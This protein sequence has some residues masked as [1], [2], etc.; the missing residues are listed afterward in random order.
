MKIEYQVAEKSSSIDPATAENV[1]L[2]AS[3][4]PRKSK[5]SLFG[6]LNRCSS[7]TGIRLL[8]SNLYQPPID[9]DIINDRLELVEELTQDISLFNNL[10][11]IIAKFP[12]L[13][14]VLNLCVKRPEMNITQMEVKLDR[15]I[16][17]KQIL[18][19]LP[20]L[21]EILSKSNSNICKEATKMLRS[22]V[23][24][25]TVLLEMMH[26]VLLEN[27]SFGK[28][29]GA[30]K[31][32]RFMA[33][34]PEVNS[35]LDLARTTFC[36]Y[37][38]LLES[39]V[40]QLAETHE[41][42]MKLQWNNNKGF[43]IQI[44]NSK[45]VQIDVKKL[46]IEFQR[47]VKTKTGITFITQ[48]FAVKDSIAKN[49]LEEVSKL[50]NA[51]LNELLNEVREYIGFLYKLS[52]T[53]AT[54]DMLVAFANVSMQEDYI[55]P[56]FGDS[57]VIRGGRHPNL[58]QIDVDLT[59]NDTNVD[60]FSRLHILTGPNM[61]GKSTYLRQV[62]LLTIMAQIGCFVPAQFATFRITDRIFSRVSTKDCIETNSSTFM[63]EMQETAFI[64]SNLGPSSLVIIDELGRGTSVEEGTAICWAV[65]ESLLKSSSFVFLAT[66]FMQMTCLAEVHPCVE[67][68][69]FLTQ[70]ESNHVVYT[71]Q[72]VKG[73]L[74][75]QGS[76]N[77]NID[78]DDDTGGDINSESE[79]GVVVNYGI[80]LA[81][82]SAF[83]AN[84]VEKAKQISKRISKTEVNIVKVNQLDNLCIQYVVKLKKLANLEES[85]EE[86]R[87]ELERIKNN[88]IEESKNLPEVIEAEE[89]ASNNCEEHIEENPTASVDPPVLPE[90]KSIFHDSELDA[91]NDKT[92][93][94]CKS[95][96]RDPELD[97]EME[98]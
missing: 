37:V 83:P 85:D 36:E 53:V 69:H 19:V 11:N 62:V 59:P 3:L 33:V 26:L 80:D 64:L 89:R 9:K 51:I 42:P 21:L 97:K 73:R 8:R 68:Y 47:I 93:D 32:T 72:L 18:E 46:P 61:S 65:C 14:S 31:F 63:V 81:S 22:H 96:C 58:E 82:R 29:A 60:C 40:R 66:H 49:S 57:L 24:T 12:E 43:C 90:I 56:E 6:L 87:D 52:E 38:E 30:S 74:A 17:L 48:E 27:F 4:G 76:K 1:E 39:D 10:R 20:T 25:S 16:F 28:G 78:D 45:N 23:Q 71:H 67:N 2:L 41:L 44:T 86:V 34:R 88:F 75:V 55:K 84:F 5:L 35:L 15:M 95:V 13:D 92:S 54:L 94:G 77:D 50:S 7:F 98:F 70:V 91:D 79:E